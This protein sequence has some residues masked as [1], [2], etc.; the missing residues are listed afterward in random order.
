M[1]FFMSAE[2]TN[3]FSSYLNRLKI[4]DFGTFFRSRFVQNEK[5]HYE[6][7]CEQTRLTENLHT[8]VEV[9]Y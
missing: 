4:P 5:S 9:V 8:P 6:M 3:D 7:K 1:Q 2:F